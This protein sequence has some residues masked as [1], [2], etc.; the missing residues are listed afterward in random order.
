MVLNMYVRRFKAF[1]GKHFATSD[2]MKLKP[3]IFEGKK[4]KC[5]IEIRLEKRLLEV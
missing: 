3:G 1:F 4:W 5:N 2:V